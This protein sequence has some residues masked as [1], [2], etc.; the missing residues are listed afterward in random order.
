[1]DFSAAVR[2]GNCTKVVPS[3]KRCCVLLQNNARPTKV[4]LKTSR[5]DENGKTMA[6]DEAELS[7]TVDEGDEQAGGQ[8]GRTRSQEKS[9]PSSRLSGHS[10]AIAQGRH[11]QTWL[12]REERLGPFCPQER[13]T[14]AHFLLQCMRYKQPRG[15]CFIKS[16]K[17]RILSTSLLSE[18][19]VW[20][21]GQRSSTAC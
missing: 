7:R 18:T 4:R 12:P 6:G 11:R 15:Q 3:T 13:E 16:Y 20:R 8:A 19:S 17:Y 1:M 21:E 5:G 14:E 10:L 2:K 9:L